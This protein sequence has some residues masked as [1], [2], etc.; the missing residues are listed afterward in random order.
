MYLKSFPVSSPLTVANLRTHPEV[1][2]EERKIGWS[3]IQDLRGLYRY[4]HIYT[5]LAGEVAVTNA[6]H[7]NANRT[8][9]AKPLLCAHLSPRHTHRLTS[10]RCPTAQTKACQTTGRHEPSGPPCPTDADHLQL[11]HTL[12]LLILHH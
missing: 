11:N 6:E 8:S 5:H 9:R 1:I 4:P 10:Q 2:Q 3:A 7:G 12:I